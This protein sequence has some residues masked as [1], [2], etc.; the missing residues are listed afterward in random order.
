MATQT[1]IVTRSLR[2][3]GVI[4]AGDTPA[5]AD[6]ESGKEALTA[7]VNAWEAEGLS[8]DIIPLDARFEQGIVALLAVRLAEEYGKAPS[9]VLVRDANAGWA[10]IESA[11]FAVP[12]SRFEN[13]LKYT[14]HYTDIGFIIGDQ[15]ENYDIWQASTAYKLRRFVRNGANLYECITEGTS[16][17]SGGPTGT[18][19]VITDGTAEWCWRR[20]AGEPEA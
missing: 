17:S 9:E 15:A 20:V 12:A 7:M 6:L 2:R 3:L 13:A 18:D 5:H 8:G 14:G 19:A 1:E 16:A 4:A 10:A 11:F